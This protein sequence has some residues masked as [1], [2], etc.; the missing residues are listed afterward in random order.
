MS[1]GL[2]NIKK[3]LDEMSEDEE[4]DLQVNTGGLDEV[5]EQVEG[6]RTGLRG[7][8]TVIDSTNNKM[9]GL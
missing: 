5:G 3:I 4:I 2:E 7:L 9:V 1:Q 8:E 6:A